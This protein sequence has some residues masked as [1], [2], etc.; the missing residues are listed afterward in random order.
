MGGLAAFAVGVLVLI[1]I[2]GSVVTVDA[3][4]RGVKM[5]FGKVVGEA[6]DPG[7]HFKIPMIENVRPV[8]V[9]EQKLKL[10]TSASSK[11]LQTVKSHIVV[12]FHPVSDQVSQLYNN[13]GLE[14]KE[15]VLDPAVEETVKA[16]TAQYTAEEL[17]SQRTD[18]RRGMEEMLSERVKINQI[19]ITKFNIVNFEF[20]SSFNDAIE[21][22]QTAEQ[23]ALQAE[24]E[25][26]RIEVEARQEVETARGRAESLKL[27]AEAQAEAI[28]M[29]AKA[30]AEAQEM[31]A[32]VINNDVVKLRAIEK[33]DGVMPRVT[34]E[35]V[36]FIGVDG[37]A[38]PIPSN[39]KSPD[40]AGVQ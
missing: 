37:A 8:E 2:I 36:P 40:L 9:R 26:R 14:Y 31:L 6:L 39:P 23:A 7:L 17:I 18:V 13:I 3:G 12:N 21:A 22:K 19:Q 15:R 1:G 20:S 30:E 34:G 27:E 32:K 5:R 24:N 10:E 29:T 4:Y 16:I 28:R 38:Q 35:V 25:L 33:W 11:D